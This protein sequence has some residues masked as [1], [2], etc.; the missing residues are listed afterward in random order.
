MMLT[1]SPLHGLVILILFERWKMICWMQ[2]GKRCVR[3]M[4]GRLVA[5]QFERMSDYLFQK[6]LD[7]Q[8]RPSMIP[9]SVSIT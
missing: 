5:Q 3:A 8:S 7:S 6:R 2:H 4:I 1:I 9:T